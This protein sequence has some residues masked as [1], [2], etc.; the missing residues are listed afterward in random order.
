MKQ[1][2]A[3]AH[4]QVMA[5]ALVLFQPLMAVEIIIEAGTHVHLLV[6]SELMVKFLSMAIDL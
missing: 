1:L 2:N 5:V 6:E 3:Q 4:V